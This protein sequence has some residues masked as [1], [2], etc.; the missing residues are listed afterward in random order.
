MI[1]NPKVAV[2]VLNYNRSNDTI[3]CINSLLN[4]HYDNYSIL[5]VDNCSTDESFK[6]LKKEY[7]QLDVIQ[8]PENMGYTGGVNYGIKYLLKHEYH[9]ILNINNDT[10]VEPDF[11]GKLVEAAKKDIDIAI[12]CGTILCEHSREII[13]YGPGKMVNWRGVA[14]HI[15]KNKKYYPSSQVMKVNFISGC[16]ML[17]RVSCLN[18]IGLLDERFFMYL[19]DIEYSNRVLKKGYSMIYVPNSIIY[20]KVLDEKES[21]FKV[22]YSV[23]NR[24]LLIKQTSTG[25]NRFVAKIYF[26]IVITIKLGVWFFFKKDFFY[27]AKYGLQDYYLNRF[28]QGRGMLFLSNRY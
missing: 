22:Y 8:T 24:L 4:I 7:K 14:I 9:Y 19:D 27:A 26:I 13:W 3:E 11:L 18:D 20:H 28:Y 17:I 10:I 23:R 2:I 6:I 1:Y 15:N 16:L 12:T 25:I 5:V 21:A